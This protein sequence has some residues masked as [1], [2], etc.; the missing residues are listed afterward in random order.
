M[1]ACT[2][3]RLEVA[4]CLLALSKDQKWLTAYCH[5]QQTRSGSQPVGTFK[6]PKVAHSLLALSKDQMWLTTCWH[7]QKTIC[8]FM[9]TGTF[10]R[11]EWLYACWHF[12]KT[13]CGSQPTS[14]F[15]RLNVALS[16]LALPKSQTWLLVCWCLLR[17][18]SGT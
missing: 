13:R 5:F 15:K 11:L 2:F 18:S 9:S 14:T 17:P 10:K 16:L 12:Q 7:F 1:F 3:K 8:G 6:R 4:L